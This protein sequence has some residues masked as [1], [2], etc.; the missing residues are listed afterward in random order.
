MD[1]VGG[2]RSS[3]GTVEI[4]GTGTCVFMIAW[5]KWILALPC[6]SGPDMIRKV[7]RAFLCL[8]SVIE[9]VFYDSPVFTL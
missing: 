4:W 8:N 5:L 7:Q 9:I 6:E 1:A 3:L 2:V